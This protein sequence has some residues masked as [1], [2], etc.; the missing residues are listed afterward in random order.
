MENRELCM[1]CVFDLLRVLMIVEDG[2]EDQG[3][4]RVEDEL[5]NKKIEWKMGGSWVFK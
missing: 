2:V 1:M 5:E 3:E 4:D